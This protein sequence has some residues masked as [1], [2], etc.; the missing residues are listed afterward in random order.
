MPL[1]FKERNIKDHIKNVPM[2]DQLKEAPASEKYARYLPSKEEII[3]IAELIERFSGM[4]VDE[5]VKRGEI[6][7]KFISSRNL[8][9]ERLNDELSACDRM[10]LEPRI[11]NKVKHRIKNVSGTPLQS[12][13][14]YFEP[15]NNTIYVLYDNFD[16]LIKEESLAYVKAGIIDGKIERH[17]FRKTADAK[18]TEEIEKFV[19][20]DVLSHELTHQ[21]FAGNNPQYQ[22]TVLETDER[23]FKLFSETVK[24]EANKDYEKLK[25]LSTEVES[26]N[27]HATALHI[28]REAIACSVTHNVMY[29]LGFRIP[30][31]VRMARLPPQYKKGISFLDEI[32]RATGQNPITFTMHDPPQSMR[33]IE[34]PELYIRR[35]KR[36]VWATLD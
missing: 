30:A 9:K 3:R 18:S 25:E 7:V 19:V 16:K 33:E 29:E 1:I 34:N 17:F 13:L 22:K 20:R 6:E 21:I 8:R 36:E 24:A 5:K 27:D 35:V 23:A 32:N 2:S 26:N 31:D 10:N 12:R 14:A 4:K 15:K 28:Y 11:Y